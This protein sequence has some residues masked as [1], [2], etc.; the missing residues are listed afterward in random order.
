MHRKKAGGYETKMLIMVSWVGRLQGIV[1]LLH[2]QNMFYSEY[3]VGLMK[4]NPEIHL[5]QNDRK[6]D[7]ET[8]LYVILIKSQSQHTIMNLSET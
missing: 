7:T 6:T 1:F 8:I 4:Q 5:K 2:S 3:V